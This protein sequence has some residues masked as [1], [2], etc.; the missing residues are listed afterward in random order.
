MREYR[1]SEYRV[2]LA[3]LNGHGINQRADAEPA[4]NAKFC[5]H[6]GEQTIQFCVHC[7]TPLRGC[8][9]IEGVP[10]PNRWDVPNHC[11][12]CGAAY[13]WTER[14]SQALADA[15][16]ELDVLDADE[17]ERLKKSIPD[18]L[19]ETPKSETAVLRFKKAAAKAGAA[20]GNLLMN[21]LGKVA[22]DAVKAKLGL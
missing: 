5:P 18:I 10:G 4:L 1:S 12:E 7:K 6:C 20:G 9:D 15:I 22:A 3:C 21:I 2:G 8:L 16:D 11:Y 17:R 13:P 19:V 14:R